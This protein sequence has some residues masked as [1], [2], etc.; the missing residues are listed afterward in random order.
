MTNIELYLHEL[1]LPIIRVV[2][3]VIE[4]AYG[5]KTIREKCFRIL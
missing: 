3:F 2:V 5:E 1:I 4:S